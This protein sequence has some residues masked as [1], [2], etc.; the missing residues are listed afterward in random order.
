MMS[1]DTFVYALGILNPQLEASVPLTPR[2]FVSRMIHR[3]S[4][5]I[6]VDV[7]GALPR[8]FARIFVD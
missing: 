1:S 6:L 2:H 7:L 8:Q 5:D 3:H 4:F